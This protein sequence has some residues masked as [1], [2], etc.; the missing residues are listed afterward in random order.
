MVSRGAG[1]T[2]QAR[3]DLLAVG[4]IASQQAAHRLAIRAGLTQAA[5]DGQARQIAEETFTGTAGFVWKILLDL[6]QAVLEIGVR[7][8]WGHSICTLYR[9]CV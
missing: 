7:E 3:M 1:V 9:P 5:V 8:F 2:A 4:F 6:R